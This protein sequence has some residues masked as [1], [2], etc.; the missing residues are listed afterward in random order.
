MA[1]EPEIATTALAVAWAFG[2]ATVIAANTATA[3]TVLIL[4]IAILLKFLSWL[5]TINRIVRN[6]EL[7]TLGKRGWPVIAKCDPA[8]ERIARSRNGTSDTNGL[9]AIQV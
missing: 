6:H 3:K 8:C 5:K 2:T 1:E 7:R 4:D 9:P